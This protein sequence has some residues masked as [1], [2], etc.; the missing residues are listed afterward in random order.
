MQDIA[1]EVEI[2]LIAG[3]AVE[4]D[5][6]H[7]DL[8]MTGNDGPLVRPRSIPWQQEAVH[9]LHARLQKS[10]IA[11][12]TIV[13]DRGLQQM[14]D[15]VKLVAGGLR[16]PLHAQAFVVLDVIGVEIATGL[17]RSRDFPNHLLGL[18]AKFG[19]RLRL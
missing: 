1:G 7:F 12:R 9:K 4:L 17:L 3:S 16:L 19:Q 5:Q 13:C 11:G 18:S 6:R 2:A 14:A 10:G 8:W 15:A